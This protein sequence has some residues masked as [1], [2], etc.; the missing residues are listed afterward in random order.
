MRYIGYHENKSRGTFGFPIQLY[1]VDS[2]HPQYEMPFHW[3]M[4]CELILVLAGKF[5]LSINGVSHTL[6]K[7]QSVFIPSEF[8]HGGTP[9]NCTY[10]CV[11]FDMESFL[12][13]SPKC[14]EKYNNA[15]DSGVISEMIF[16]PN[17][18]AGAMVDSLFENM[19][20]GKCGIHLYHNRTFVAAYR[21]YNR[22]KVTNCTLCSKYR[23]SQK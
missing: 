7:G 20:K 8:I 4:E 9:E 10:E 18:T 13:Q 11:V 5:H 3:H 6:E 17:S 16:E 21:L 2:S 15:L 22:T 14:I 19:E 1:Y 12:S 23:I